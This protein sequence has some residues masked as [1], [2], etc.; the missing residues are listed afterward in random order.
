GGTIAQDFSTNASLLDAPLLT[1]QY[2]VTVRCST[3]KLC[4]DTDNVVVN[5]LDQREASAI[6][7]ELME[8]DPAGPGLTFIAHE[9]SVGS[10]SALNMVSSDL[11]GT[12]GELRQTPV[13]RSGVEA[14]VALRADL[15]SSG[16]MQLTGVPGEFRFTLPLAADVGEIDGFLAQ[17]TCQNIIGTLGRL[18]VGGSL[19]SGRGGPDPAGLVPCP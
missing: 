9:P 4:L 12:G 7:G 8:V 11:L 10:C 14:G 15:C 1:T 6:P 18:K 3:D 19:E 2:T 5:V 16:A 17:G 13:D